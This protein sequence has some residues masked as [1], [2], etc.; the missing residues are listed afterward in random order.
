MRV[1]IVGCGAVARLFY[2]PALR[3]LAKHGIAQTLAVVDPSPAARTE[4]GTALSARPCA[5]LA[6]AFALGGELAIIATPPKF[7][8]ESEPPLL[9]WP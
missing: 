4:L 1:A 6:E 8:R 9:R 5:T 7:H 2:Q 3:E